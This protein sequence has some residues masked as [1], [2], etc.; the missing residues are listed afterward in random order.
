MPMFPLFGGK[1]NSTI[2]SLILSR[3]AVCNVFQRF[4]R[5]ANRV[6]RSSSATGSW[7]RVG[8][9]AIDKRLG[10]AVDL[11]NRDLHSCLDRIQSGLRISPRFDRLRVETHCRTI[12]KI[13]LAQKLRRG[14]AVV[15]RRPADKTEAG[16][17]NDLTDAR[18][19]LAVST[20]NFETASRLSISVAIAGITLRPS[21]SI[22]LMSAS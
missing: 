18:C 20:K 15:H 21:A 12:R 7:P 2:A 6:Q 9:A 5:R 17:R 11:G 1:Q 4:R 16:E 10:G 14:G 22:A 19:R 3:G 8:N 13:Q